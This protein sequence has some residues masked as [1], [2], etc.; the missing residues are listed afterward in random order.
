MGVIDASDFETYSP[1]FSGKRG[2]R[3]AD[4]IMRLLSVDR[5]N[6]V[7]DNAASLEGSE[8]TSH[9]LG[10]LGVDYLV[11]NPERLRLLPEGSFITI[12]NHP[13]GGLD[14]II[15]IDLM[16]AIRPDYR[17]MVNRYLDRVRTLAGNFLTVTP[18][19]NV[20]EGIAPGS[21]KGIR[22][23]LLHIRNGHPAGFFPSGAVSDFSIRDM[24]IRDRRWQEGIIRFIRSVR[25]PV[26][27]IRFTGRNSSF[28]YLLGL[29][30][31]RIRTLRM[32]SELFNKAG[33]APRIIIGNLITAEE[34]AV[35][36][37]LKTFG[38]FLRESVYAMTQPDSYMQ[39]SVLREK[40][41]SGRI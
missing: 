21:L 9:L 6:Q 36:S 14:G 35:F 12:A 17:F 16:A 1:F 13:Y 29:I 38:S 34:Q 23:S 28:F 5:V 8:F 31:W 41:R 18:T 32:P 37:D 4:A 25:V 33:T 3:M 22:E 11:G 20:Q 24:R 40:I 27:P 19:G 30:S 7:Y 26:L 2:R 10:D 15:L 39:A